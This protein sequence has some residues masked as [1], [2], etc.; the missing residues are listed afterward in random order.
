MYYGSKQSESFRALA[1]DLFN[2]FDNFNYFVQR[3]KKYNPKGRYQTEE[4]AL[5]IDREIEALLMDN[6]VPFD[7]V[8]G[9]SFAAADISS[10]VLGELAKRQTSE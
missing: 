1:W 3:E 5:R 2:E 8:T 10:R 4:K 6:E 7:Y 9:N